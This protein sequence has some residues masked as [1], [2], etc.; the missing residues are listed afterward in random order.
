MKVD[1]GVKSVTELR[2]HV[3]AG[4][5]R[6]ERRTTAAQAEGSVHSLHSYEK[7]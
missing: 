5:V 7:S 2:A 6:F 1:I 3:K 4:D